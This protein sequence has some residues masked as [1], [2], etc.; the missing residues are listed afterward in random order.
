L[1]CCLPHYPDPS[2]SFDSFDP[3]NFFN[4]SIKFVAVVC[5]KFSELTTPQGYDLPYREW[6]K[7]RLNILLM[8]ARNR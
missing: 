5:R 6:E 4:L 2:R 7:A 3:F 1:T 8:D